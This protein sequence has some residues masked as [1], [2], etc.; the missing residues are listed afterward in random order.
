MGFDNECIQNIQ[1]LPGEYF[2]PV[3]RTLIYPNE[4][5][6]SQCTHLYCKPCLSYIVATTHA[7]PYDGYL[8][9]EADSKP[10]IE[11][12]KSLAD[13]I[14]N[15]AVYCLYHRSG[16]QWQGTLSDSITHC[17]GCSFGNSPVVCNRCGTQIIHRQVQEHAQICP[18]L[19]PQAQQ[20]ENAQV[21]ASTVQNQAVNQDTSVAPA[22]T[23]STSSTTPASAASTTA[24]TTISS[25]VTPTTAAAA[26]PASASAATPATSSQGQTQ[27]NATTYPQAVT[28][29]PTPEQW[30]QQQQLQYQQYYQQYPGYYP[31]QQQ[32]QQYG[33]YQPQFYQQYS[34]P[35]MLVAPQHATQGQQQPSPYMPQQPHIQHHPQQQ[36][37]PQPQ[38]QLQPQPQPQPQAQL[39]PQP[40]LQLQPQPQAQLQP[41]PQTQAQ[42]QPQ[43][44]PQ[45]QAQLQPQPQPQLQSQPQPLPQAQPH[46][47]AAQPQLPQQHLPQPQ[48]PHPQLQPHPHAQVPQ[49]QAQ[50][51]HVPAQHPHHHPQTTHPQPQPHP[52][53]QPPQQH[54]GLQQSIPP[55]QHPQPQ[56]QHP[57]AHPQG[58]QHQPYPQPQSQA[59]LHAHSQP[60]FQQQP[61]QLQPHP[62]SQ[63]NIQP[64]PQPVLQPQPQYPSAR[65]VTGHQSYPHPQS[66]QQIPPGAPQQR[67]LHM[68]PQQ[69]VQVQNQFP[70][71]QPPQMRP[72]HGHLSMQVQQQSAMPH[73]Q[74]PHTNLHPSQQQVHQH[75]GMRPQGPQQGLPPLQAQ[76]HMHP[77][78]AH[79]QG[80][81]PPQHLIHPQQ[82]VH[83]QGPPY[84]QQSFPAQPHSQQSLPQSQGMP[85]LPAQAV[86]GRPA[87]MV[88]HGMPQQ[89]FQQSTGGPTKLMQPDMSHKSPSQ[90]HMGR[91]A[92]HLAIL[93]ELQPG[94]VQQSQL[95]HSGSQGTLVPVSSVMR[96]GISD[97]AG[98]ASELEA[99]MVS[100]IAEGTEAN[101]SDHAQIEAS[102]SAEVKIPSSKSAINKDEV[103]GEGKKDIQPDGDHKNIS[104]SARVHGE[105]LE[106]HAKD[107]KAE[108]PEIKLVKKEET[109]NLPDVG[110]ESSHV[111]KDVQGDRVIQILEA[112]LKEKSAHVEGRDAHLSL[113]ATETVQSGQVPTE[114]G[115]RESLGS[116]S[117]KTSQT[118]VSQGHISGD[119]AHVQSLQQV[120]T[121]GGLDRSQLQQSS[122]Q[123]A[124]SAN[125]RAFLQPGYHDRNPSQ[126]MGQGPGSGVLQGMPPAGPAPSHERFLHHIPYGHPS[127]MMDAAQRPPVPHNVPHPGPIQERRFQEPLHPMQAHG[128]ASQIRPHGSNFP[129][130]L[131]HPG[132]RSA[133]PE[134]FQPPPGQQPYGSYHS[135]VPSAG[136]P[137]AGLSTSSARAP[138]HFG[139][140][141]KG[142]P[143][144]AMTPQGQG[145]GHMLP[146][147]VGVARPAFPDGR[148]PEPPFA[149]SNSV[150]PNGIPGQRPPIGHVLTE[151]R[152]R[153][154]TEERF[155][156]LPEDGTRAAQDERFRPF[157]MDHG[158]GIVNRKEFEEDLK[159]FPRPAHLDGEGALKLDG[160]ISSS[161]PLPGSDGG[162]SA[163]P[164]RPLLPYQSGGPFPTSS[165]G[166]EHH[167]MD[168]RERHRPVGFPEDLGRKYDPALA[169]PDF[170][171][172]VSEFGRRRMDALPPLRSPGREYS[173]LPSSRFGLGME[174]FD[175]R[176][177]RG[178]SERS[179]ALDPTGS[180]YHDSKIPIPSA[181]GSGG[182]PSHLFKGVPDGHGSHRMEQLGAGYLT[183]TNRSGE[184]F[185]ARNL[186]SLLRGGEPLGQG[187]FRMGE[188]TSFGGFSVPGRIRAGDPGFS[189]SYPMHGFPNE[190]GHPTSGDMDA[191]EFPRKRMPGSMG[192]CRICR[193]DCETVE[194]LDMH[195]Q[196]REHQKMAMD[197][198]LCIKQEIAKKQRISEVNMPL[199]DSNKS[200]KASF[201][202]HGNRQ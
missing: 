73:P 188:P 35:Q 193:I 72:P 144:Q 181:P 71:Q 97:K 200:R 37:Q 26:A 182:L 6:Q 49:M 177:P 201:E 27:A 111:L 86:A 87:M 4:A 80:M 183:G 7:C 23:T 76:S 119:S 11:S 67:P 77:S 124:F 89:S 34:Q 125:E 9:T 198:I 5:L 176:D 165:L 126:F 68:H 134:P 48:Q 84:I 52:Q 138:T 122:R 78:L 22:S 129:E 56:M 70:S 65:A 115:R 130:T 75:P 132:Q 139:L 158:R 60:Q 159:Q 175:G 163:L 187:Q 44:Q 17:T 123:N 166:P 174:N 69:P 57:Q 36:A 1:S 8:V 82:P 29:A 143:D 101:K 169:L 59:Y 85:T 150:K 32:Y 40:Q 38:A 21:Q 64:Q 93:S 110:A 102:E 15:V 63:P 90:N 186:P 171:S 133:V 179:K 91:S 137:V 25:T 108:V 53:V 12:N 148:Q 112:D 83:P 81:P 154:F 19:Q 31:Y 197:M 155:R 13:T 113:D 146:P 153:P 195:S 152:F 135:E 149:Q 117:Q 136:P 24:A 161:R 151:D 191:F 194:G 189:S 178:F 66:L 2:C 58:P 20:V 16:C 45:A 105:G 99:E 109:T 50:Q 54:P 43:P 3:C 41:Q 14:G 140:P 10:L 167:G 184:A 162:P 190:A 173:G 104:E 196:T 62:Q 202:N 96:P 160:Y 157:A 39:Q 61:V 100:K 106:S 147:H 164:S 88:S 156:L 199:E 170:R 98:H 46:P 74:G 118:I 116:V 18:G 51:I 103:I 131:P 180:T 92:A 185:G 120:S 114:A 121:P 192:W 42:L 141:Q 107:E 142:F 94:P 95:A 79:Q 47:Q 30:Y 145:Q 55:Q 33:Q 128:I 127:N 172:S 28:Q 168:I